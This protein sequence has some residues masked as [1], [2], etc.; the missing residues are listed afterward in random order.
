MPAQ[1]TQVQAAEAVS[2]RDLPQRLLKLL[3]LLAAILFSLTAF[4]SLDWLHST[5][6]HRSS[7]TG[8]APNNCRIRDAVRHHALQPNCTAVYPW[9]S[10]TYQFNTNSLGFRDEKVREVPL[11]DTKPRILILGDS[12]TEGM[13]PW[14][15]SYVSMVAARFPEYDFLNG[16]VVSYSPSNYLNVTRMVLAKG[17]DIDE[18]MVFIDMSDVQDEGG[19][20]RDVDSSGAVTSREKRWVISSY[21]KWR[22]R[23]ANH[24]SITNHLLLSLERFLVR[25]GYYHLVIGLTDNTFD[26]ERAA[27]TYRKVNESEPP[28]AGYAPLGVEGGIAKEKEKMTLLWQ[29]LSQRQ[30]P[31]SVVV[32]PHP[33]QLAHDTVDSRQVR[34]WQ[35]W[36]DGKCK[37]FISLFP[38]FFA[39]REHCPPHQPG[40][41]YQD[42]FIFGDFHFNPAGNALV[43]DAVIE[44]LTEQPPAKRSA[45]V[46]RTP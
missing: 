30:I 9:G 31:L 2:R 3:L 15:D 8:V 40:C 21:A 28:E 38:A 39:V 43:A 12:M 41:W 19:F 45:S 29:Q 17:V 27:W 46:G 13:L 16:A 42:L 4:L 11:A 6:L 10:G 22:Y 7:Q 20:Y 34:I 32:Y 23:I 44:S 33:S 25:H 14:N 18:V 36:C 24:L 37:R 1:L 26:M 35:Q 5:G